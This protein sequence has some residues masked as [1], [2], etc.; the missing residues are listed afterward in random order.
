MTLAGQNA[1]AHFVAVTL[2][3]PKIRYTSDAQCKHAVTMRHCA[4]RGREQPKPQGLVEKD[5]ASC[6]S[7]HR[8]PVITAGNLCGISPEVPHVRVVRESDTM[9]RR[10][11][12]LRAL[13]VVGLFTTLAATMI[14]PGAAQQEPPG[15][16]AMD[17]LWQ[18]TAPGFTWGAN[19]IYFPWIANDEDFGLGAADTS[20]SVQNLED[21]D[22]QI[23]IYRG[24]GDNDWELATTATLSAYASK[25]FSAQQLGIASGDGAPVA[26]RGFHWIPGTTQPGVPAGGFLAETIVSLVNPINNASQVVACVVNAYNADGNLGTPHPFVAATGFTWNDI[27]YAQGATIEWE[28]QGDLQE[29]LN[30]A[31]ADSSG[32][33]VNPFGGL[34]ADGDCHDALD[35]STSGFLDSLRIA[36]VAKAAATGDNLP[37]TSVADTAVSGYNAINGLEVSSFNAWYLPIVQTNC[38][39][40]GCWDSMIRVANL[41]DQNSAVTIRFFPHDNAAGSL[42][43]GFQIEQLVDGGDTWNVHLGSLVPQ[44][45]IGS[46][47]IYS[48]GNV[49][50]MVDRYKVGYNM[51][52]TNTGS[53]A[54]FESEAQMPGAA[55]RYALFAP[56]VLMDYFGWNTGINVANLVDEH[57]NISIQYFNMLGNATQVLSQRLAPYG[58]TY[59]YDP[60]VNAQNISSQDVVADP[61]SGVVGSAIVWSDHPVAAAVDATKYPETDPRG[62]P[63]LFQ[64][65]SY[66][67]TQNVFT[68]QAVP[69]VQ[70]GNPIDGQGATSGINIMNPNAAATTANVYFVDQSGFN[71]QNFGVS[72]VTIPGFANGFVYT[73]WQHNLPDGFYGAAQVISSLPV[74]AVSANVDYQVD[75]DGSTIF[76]AFNPCGHY[77]VAGA[78][79]SFEGP[80]DISGGSVTKTW[81]NLDDE[82]V[83]GVQ[84]HIVSTDL[85]SPYQRHGISG[86]DGSTTFDDV[87]PGTYHLNVDA[88]P[89]IYQMPERPADVF[90][91]DEGE[92]WEETNTLDFVVDPQGPSGLIT[93]TVCIAGESG[94]N[95]E[96]WFECSD[97]NLA[98]VNVDI[99]IDPDLDPVNFPL[100]PPESDLRVFQGHTGEDGSVTLPLAPG[101]YILCVYEDPDGTITTTDGV[102][103]TTDL[104]PQ[105][106]FLMEC[107]LLYGEPF[108][109]E[110]DDDLHLINEA[111]PTPVQTP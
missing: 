44:G 109:I 92:D 72:G 41:S 12:S 46:A 90:T 6:C 49:F 51:W 96:Y 40:G 27:T 68:W 42:D 58:M 25:T 24:I 10:A 34:N 95:P 26:V 54:N 70:K 106:N 98:G 99:Y 81:L 57:N 13:L 94:F 103:V 60:S 61:N 62:G 111:I 8:P 9:T 75:G 86:M 38:G 89:A 105:I 59:F 21:R 48:D 88:L 65:T 2:Y 101:N 37:F 45:W 85:D 31:N 79:C 78:L 35:A 30:A 23:W 64:A 87:P 71:A 56:H 39:P 16:P 55:G 63:D 91:L 33:L 29:I 28:T 76:N 84:F 11:R 17:S 66:N 22:G 52:I 32:A 69:L 36:G 47:H 20:I 100:T 93:K 3:S 108:T 102:E 15:V 97:V 4:G 5:E 74:A 80:I 7:C 110:A 14:A 1:I 82:P 83:V 18:S 19:A 53:A 73:L 50:A 107:V 77:R 43:T 67:A 104:P